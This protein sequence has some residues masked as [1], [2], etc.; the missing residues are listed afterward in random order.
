MKGVLFSGGSIS[1]YTAPKTAIETADVVICADSG[2]LHAEKIGVVADVWVGDL[3][4]VDEKHSCV[5]FV[6]LPTEKDD[7][8]TMSA[9]RILVKKGVKSVRMFGC[10]GTRLDH[11]YAN[12]FV[13]KFLLDN[14]VSAT[15][16]DEH[17]KVFLL[18]CGKHI[19]DAQCG[20]FLSLLPFCCEVEGLSISGVKYPLNDHTLCDS[21]PLGV[22]NQ[23][24]NE[25]CEID[26]KKG[27]LAVFLS[28]D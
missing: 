3:D 20:S 2:I 13:L 10:T 23:V 16:E 11:T 6:R 24:L 5:D 12:L 19:V 25:H 9:A 7:T 15:I 1:D 18:P 14:G 28:H 4:S 22:S 17:N 8:D 26:I 27:T 21:F